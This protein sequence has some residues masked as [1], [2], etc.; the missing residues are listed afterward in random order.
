MAGN[1]AGAQ[2]GSAAGNGADEHDVGHGEGGFGQI[3]AGKGGF[4]RPGEGEEAVEEALKP[5]GP[6]AGGG[7]E[8]ARQ[9]QGKEGGYGT[10]THGGQVAEAARQ[11]AVANRFGR[12]PVELEVAAGDGEVG[13]D[14]EFLARPWTDESTV[15]AYAQADFPGCG[16]GRPVANL[17]HESQFA[18]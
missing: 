9:T 5:G 8:L 7:G 16:A 13:G 17:G 11:G 18:H 15:V 4:I 14:G 10:S 3:A 12:M 2:E 1:R 6:A